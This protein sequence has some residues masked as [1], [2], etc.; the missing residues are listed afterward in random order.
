MSYSDLGSSDLPLNLA[1]PEGVS[2]SLWKSLYLNLRDTVAPEKLPP[3]ALTSRPVNLGMLL[4]D[5]LGLPWYR[6]VFTNLGDVVLPDTQ[7]PLQL[8][9]R[10]VD[11]GELLGDEIARPWWTSL[12]RN[13]ADW[14]APEKLPALQLESKSFN[15]V[16][17]SDALLLTNWS[18]VI[19]GPKIFLPDAARPTLT[20]ASPALVLPTLPRP[21]PMQVEF[22]NDL[23]RDLRRDLR[24]SRLRQR[25]LMLVFAAEVVFLVAGRYILNGHF[26]HR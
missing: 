6:S 8:E 24:N 21:E 23:E 22:V 4:G 16:V 10:P 9:S 14:I 17:P 12:V 25:F 1:P 26:L 13:L 5:Y 7:P 3:L 11:V 20:T 2:R 18:N 19:D 15:P